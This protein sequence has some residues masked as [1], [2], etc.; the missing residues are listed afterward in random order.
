MPSAAQQLLADQS[1]NVLGV[2][3]QTIH[4][5]NNGRMDRSGEGS[6]IR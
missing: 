3:H 4:V 1:V 6:G 5:E 2:E